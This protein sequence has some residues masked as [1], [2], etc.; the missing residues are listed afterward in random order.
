MA[1]SKAKSAAVVVAMAVVAAGFA[2]NVGV[3]Y[4]PSTTSRANAG[5]SSATTVVPIYTYPTSNMSAKVSTKLGDTFIV[6]LT[7]DLAATGYDWKVNTSSGVQLTRTAVV[8]SST[9]TT[10][11][12][13]RNYYFQSTQAGNQTI[14]L[15]DV[16][17]VGAPGVYA[18]VVI[19]VTV[20]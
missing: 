14:T 15:Q 4:F 2:Y 5:T 17:L 1:G 10:G 6:Q 7:S 3:L 19:D 12:V 11:P 18:T 9:L 20:A 8:S 16:H 13:V